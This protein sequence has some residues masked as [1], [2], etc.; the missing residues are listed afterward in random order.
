MSGLEAVVRATDDAP[1]T[2]PLAAVFWLHRMFGD[3]D[4]DDATCGC[5]ATP[6]EEA[7]EEAFGADRWHDAHL[8]AAVL[9]WLRDE[10][11]AEGMRDHVTIEVRRG[12]YDTRRL[13][14]SRNEARATAALEAVAE[15]L[16][17]GER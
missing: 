9:D 11:A 15:R 3:K 4:A 7:C 16:A 10:L 5:G 14:Q 6:P 8:A 13:S 17:G 2:D 1:S 12:A